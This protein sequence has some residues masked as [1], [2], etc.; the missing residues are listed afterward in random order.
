M[1]V[2]NPMEI[3]FISYLVSFLIIIYLCHLV[4]NFSAHSNFGNIWRKTIHLGISSLYSHSIYPFQ[5]DILCERTNC[6]NADNTLLE[7]G[8]V[9]SLAL[10]LDLHSLAHHLCKMRIFYELRRVTLG[11]TRNFVEEWTKMA[12]ESPKNN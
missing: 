4:V 9:W 6:T 5:Y 1:R 11:N 7:S 2:E 3:L 8:S 12:R 10:E